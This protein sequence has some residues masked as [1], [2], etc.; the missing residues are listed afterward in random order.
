MAGYTAQDVRDL[1][2]RE[3]LSMTQAR[4]RLLSAQLLAACDNAKTVEEL[5]KV[6]RV[7]VTY[8]FGAA[9]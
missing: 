5:A 2:Q 4:E 3:G 8:A 1:A 9:R 7:L 6:V